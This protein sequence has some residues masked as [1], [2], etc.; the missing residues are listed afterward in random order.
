MSEMLQDQQAD[1][2]DGLPTREA[3]MVAGLKCFAEHGYTGSRLSDI[4]EQ[5]GLTTGAFYRHFASKAEFF[6]VL[7][8]AYGEEL[9]S[10]LAECSS[11]PEQVEAWIRIA[12]K[13][14]GVIRAAAEIQHIE[15][16]EVEARRRLRDTCAGLIA[17]HL[18]EVE[19]GWLRARS[20]AL[21]LCDVV[22]QYGLMEAAGWIEERDPAAVAKALGHLVDQGLYRT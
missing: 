15:P 19:G 10:T 5:T 6:H 14:R 17:A 4:V 7:F 16:A 13:H 20:A 2:T 3:L 1:G 21:L 9:Q 22:A 11:F 8:V 18:G 12:R